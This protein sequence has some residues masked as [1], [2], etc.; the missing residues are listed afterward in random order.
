MA[1]ASTTTPRH[2]LGHTLLSPV[3]H[4]VQTI[5]WIRECNRIGNE[6][7][8]MSHMSD[9]RLSMAGLKREDIPTDIIRRS[10]LF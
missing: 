9:S 1:F 8:Q 10:D 6:Y 4:L 3:R 5:E 2:G 7:E